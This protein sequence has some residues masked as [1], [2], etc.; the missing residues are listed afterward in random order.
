MLMTSFAWAGALGAACLLVASAGDAAAQPAPLALDTETTIAGV[1]VAC[2][3]IGQT[4]LDPRW[5]AYPVRV[6]FS[7]ARSEYLS[8]G[9]IALADAKGTPILDV[10]CEGPWILLKLKPGAYRVEGRIA[11]AKPRTARFKPP[12]KG[13]MRLVLQFPDL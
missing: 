9:E 12:A 10:R 3:G 5:D 8:D 2:T 7:N 13:Q 6:E 4:R 11:N 1:D